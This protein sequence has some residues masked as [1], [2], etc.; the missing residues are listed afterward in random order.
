MPKIDV[1]SE[2][3]EYYEAEPPPWQDY[4]I[5]GLW[6]VV[7]VFGLMFAAI[8]SRIRNVSGW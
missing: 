7:G 5:G 8:R 2:T 4:V 6:C 1:D 3:G